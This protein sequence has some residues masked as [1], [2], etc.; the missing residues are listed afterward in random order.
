MAMPWSQKHPDKAEELK[1][2]VRFLEDDKR[3]HTYT[4][5]TIDVDPTIRTRVSELEEK[6]TSLCEAM[7]MEFILQPARPPHWLAVKMAAHKKG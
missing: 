2:Q 5:G 3:P 1:D 4:A 7:G 6:L